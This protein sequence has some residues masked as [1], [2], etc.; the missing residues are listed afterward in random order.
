MSQPLANLD[1]PAGP[2][3]S[4]PQI[5]GAYNKMPLLMLHQYRLWFL[6]RVAKMVDKWDRKFGPLHLQVINEEIANFNNRP[7]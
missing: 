5:R 1:G 6:S 7:V 2:I 4:Y 3:E